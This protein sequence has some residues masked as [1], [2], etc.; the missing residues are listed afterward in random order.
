M[1]GS[2]SSRERRFGLRGRSYTRTFIGSIAIV[3]AC[4]IAPQLLLT[5]TASAQSPPALETL[6]VDYYDNPP[7]VFMDDD[8]APSGLMPSILDEIATR[9]GW[10]IEYRYFDWAEG[11]SAI[12][13]GE[14]D[15]F[16]VL[17][18]T[19]QRAELMEFCD[20]TLYS[21]WGQVVVPDGETETFGS[22]LDLNGAWVAVL[23]EDIHY[24]GEHGIK[25]LSESFGID[26][27]FRVE[28]SYT[29]VIEAVRNGQAD[30]GVVNRL[31][32]ATSAREAGLAQSSIVFNPVE[33]RLAFTTK[34]DM[35][36]TRRSSTDT[37]RSG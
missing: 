13:S 28:D 3:L 25:K 23:D 16:G 22:I 20:E 10:E 12:E 1:I 34:R 27:A 14:I 29:E 5:E 31:V 15:A 8:G 17:A 11:L 2:D 21:N 9:E 4:S 32:A 33:V 36:D 6:V 26:V 35:D 24:S 19:P 37:S 7:L 30:A 18:K